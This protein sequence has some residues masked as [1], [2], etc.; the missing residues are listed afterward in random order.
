MSNAVSPFQAFVIRQD[1]NRKV[2]A[3]MES[4]AVD[5]L[6]AGEVLIRVAY[7]SVNYK[8]A[9]AA[10]GAG[11]IIRRFPC[12]G[13]IDMSGTVVESAD[14]RF[15]PGDEVIATSYDIGVAHHGGY[16]EYARVPAAWTVP[17]PAGLSLFDAMALGTAGFTAAL[18]IVRMEDNGLAPANGPVVVTGASGGV[19]GLAIDMLA[20]LGYHVVALTG[21]AHEEGYLKGLGA[22]EIKLRDTIDPATTRPLDAG[23]W[24]GAVDNVGG[25]ILA[26][27]LSTMKQAGTVASIGNAQ[28]IKLNT[29]VFPFILRGVSLLGVDSGYI[30]EPTRSRVWQR[31]ATD[32]KPRHLAAMT[33]TVPFAELPGVFHD[34]I[35]GRVK[36]RTVI[37]VKE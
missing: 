15:K 20:G 22:A 19:G 31:L 8:D 27:V 14:P 10:T 37:A 9:L 13:G 5:A 1:E 4:M 23:L 25:D 30:G 32:L 33:R 12:V 21:K 18:G 7:S 26:W 35:E 11:K 3:A 29:T 36:G 6:D 28:S 16:A 34:F 17:L 2:V 24:A